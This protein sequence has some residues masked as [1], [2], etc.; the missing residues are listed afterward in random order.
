M[1]ATATTNNNNSLNSIPEVDDANMFQAARRN[2]RRN[3]LGDL[4]EQLLQG[5]LSVYLTKSL[6]FSLANASITSAEIDQMTPNF[7]SM[8]IKR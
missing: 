2:G 1:S 5:K 6:L 8:S 3:A 4:G 7:Q